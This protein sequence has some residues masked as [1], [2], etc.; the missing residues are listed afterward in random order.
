MSLKVNKVEIYKEIGGELNIPPTEVEKVVKSQFK[1]VAE[2]M[3]EGKFRPIR[4]PYFGVFFV[5]PGRIPY[6]TRKDV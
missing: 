5:R 4:L 3:K 2:V 1:L 6:L